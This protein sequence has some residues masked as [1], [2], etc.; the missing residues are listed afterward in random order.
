[1][2]GGVCVLCGLP[3]EY[4]MTCQTARRL[5]DNVVE[6]EVPQLCRDCGHEHFPEFGGICI[7]CACR[8]RW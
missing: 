4:W 6:P 5:A 7:G 8:R 1:M 2:T 3:H